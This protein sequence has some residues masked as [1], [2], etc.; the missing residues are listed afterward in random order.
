[1]VESGLI[2]IKS[3]SEYFFP[4]FD[5]S[6]IQIL[7]CMI[8]GPDDALKLLVRDSLPGIIGELISRGFVDILFNL[9]AGDIEDFFV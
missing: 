8:Q 3:Y 9:E 4:C 6:F 7:F 1:L 2:E 5:N